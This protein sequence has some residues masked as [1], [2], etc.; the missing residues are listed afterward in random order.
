MRTEQAS[1]NGIPIY[2][3]ASGLFIIGVLLQFGIWCAVDVLW[4]RFD[5]RE[6]EGVAFAS[7][8]VSLLVVIRL[9][10]APTFLAKVARGIVLS[11]GTT[12]VAIILVLVLGIPFHFMIG[13]TK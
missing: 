10:D 1:T 5:G 8:I 4:V 7:P 6:F 2:R 11:V 3:R 12:V 13:G 9:L